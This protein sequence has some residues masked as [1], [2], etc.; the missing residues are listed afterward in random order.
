MDDITVGS[1][2]VQS[3]GGADHR[4]YYITGRLISMVPIHFRKTTYFLDLE[5]CAT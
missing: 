4:Y 5:E 1:T 2:P 3:E